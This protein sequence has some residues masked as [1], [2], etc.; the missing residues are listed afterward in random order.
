MS[1][2][3]NQYLTVVR[4]IVAYESLANTPTAWRIANMAYAAI[5]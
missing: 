2:Y 4:A 3:N 1:Q 5:T